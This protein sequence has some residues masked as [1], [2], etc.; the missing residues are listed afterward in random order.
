MLQLDINYITYIYLCI[1]HIDMCI[2]TN[3]MLLLDSAAEAHSLVLYLLNIL[4][5]IS[6]EKV[7]F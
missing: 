2:S 7:R 6:L 1:K 5:K 3:I 4:V